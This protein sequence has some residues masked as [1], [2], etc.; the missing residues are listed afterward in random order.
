MKKNNRGEALK[1]L[2][3]RNIKQFRTDSGLSQA[4]LAEKAGISIPYL[5]SVERG[6]KWPSPAT[7][8]GIA[9]GLG[10][11]PYDLLKPEIA[12]SREVR[13]IVA[14]FARD[15]SA[16]AGQ[17]VKLLNSVSKEGGVSEKKEI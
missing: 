14:K 7:L 17:T 6:D 15:I 3:S 11:E 10:I 16:L 5:G 8:S 1:S 9:H 12:S 13:K 2:M 4:E